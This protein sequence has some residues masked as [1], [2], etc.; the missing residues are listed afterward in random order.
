MSH[1]ERNLLK[2]NALLRQVGGKG[3]PAC[4]RGHEIVFAPCI[5]LAPLEHLDPRDDTAVSA[6]LAQG[7][8]VEREIGLRGFQWSPDEIL[9]QQ[10]VYRHHHLGLCFLCDVPDVG[11]SV[12]LRDVVR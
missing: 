11:H 1:H 8:V 3:A 6:Y 4:M 12:K 7:L 9:R 10:P 2:C 5:L